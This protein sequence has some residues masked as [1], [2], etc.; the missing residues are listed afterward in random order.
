MAKY[1][2]FPSTKENEERA[3]YEAAKLLVT[4]AKDCDDF[5]NKA[6]AGLLGL[7]ADMLLKKCIQSNDHPDTDKRISDFIENIGITDEN[8]ELWALACVIYAHWDNEYEIKLDFFQNDLFKPYRQ[9]FND[10]VS[11]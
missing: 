9:R 4:G 6:I 11:Q 7:G 1:R 10:L 3:D 2:L 8:N 5:G